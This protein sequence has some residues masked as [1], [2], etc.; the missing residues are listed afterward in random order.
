MR[1]CV[2]FNPTARGEKANR[3]RRQ[4]DGIATEAKLRLTAD[5]G[6]ARRL[7]AEAVG[8]GFDVIV[9][10]GGDGTL[11]EVLNGIADAP[12][13]LERACLGVLPL[14]TVNVFAREVAIPAKFDQAWAVIR[15]CR[16]LRDGRT[17][18]AVAPAALA[19][20]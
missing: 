19:T 5:A 10:A 12:G 3:F 8:E 9:A 4:L 13:G 17:R 14:G 18:P 6:E 1:A 20:L 11:N 16:T 2:I 7:A 15:R